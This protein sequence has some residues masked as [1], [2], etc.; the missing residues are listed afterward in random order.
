MH[1]Q[2]YNVFG[3][4]STNTD[5]DDDDDDDDEEE[6]GRCILERDLLSV[7]TVDD[8]SSSHDKT[9]INVLKRPP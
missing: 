4:V 9:K 2:D 3:M 8:D 5:D 7:T 6:V 1:L